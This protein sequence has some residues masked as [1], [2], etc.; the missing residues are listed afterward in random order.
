MQFMFHKLDNNTSLRKKKKRKKMEAQLLP[1]PPAQ[2]Y[3]NVYEIR[4]IIEL[5]KLTILN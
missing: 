3:N 2:L 4:S 1:L 5:E